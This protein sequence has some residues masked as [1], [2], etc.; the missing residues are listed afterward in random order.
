MKRITLEELEEQYESGYIY[1]NPKIH[2]NS[3]NP[4]IIS[5]IRTPVHEITKQLNSI[6][7]PYMHKEFMLHSTNEFIEICRTI[8]K[9]RYIASLDVESLFTNVPVDT[10][11]D[12]IL[13]NVY[14]QKA[15]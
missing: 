1:G 12:I 15:S 6:I 2:K 5:Q 7:T 9:P 8:H 14:H 3:T 4:P 13:C 11:I 10:T